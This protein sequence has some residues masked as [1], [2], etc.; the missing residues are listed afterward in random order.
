VLCFD[1]TKDQGEIAML[2]ANPYRIRFATADNADALR[3]LAE[4]GSQQPLVGRVLIGLIDYTPA[5]ALSLQD[6]RVIADSSRRTDRVVAALRVRAGAVQAY[7][8]TPSLGE[9][10]RAALAAYHGE[11]VV[12]EPVAGIGHTEHEPERKAA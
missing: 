5:A 6:G 10:I 4:Q 1:T 9:R 12:P 7:E 11:V 8:A 3:R 2:A